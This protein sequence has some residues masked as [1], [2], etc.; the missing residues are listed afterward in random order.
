MIVGIKLERLA[1]YKQRPPVFVTEGEFLFFHSFFLFSFFLKNNHVHIG[2]RASRKNQD[3]QE[4][5]TCVQ[6]KKQKSIFLIQILHLICLD[7][8][9][10][11]RISFSLLQR[12]MHDAP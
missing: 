1:F 10:V 7:L 8:T 3:L 2:A 4:K 5:F 6:K 11:D 12:E 9:L